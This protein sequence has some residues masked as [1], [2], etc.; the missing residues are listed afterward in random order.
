MKMRGDGGGWRHT[1]DF[2]CLGVIVTSCHECLKHPP[3]KRR[4]DDMAFGS[5][6]ASS[7]I[8]DVFQRSG[9]VA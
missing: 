6:V 9:F 5:W 3:T 2:L 4:T 7:L 1:I 8:R